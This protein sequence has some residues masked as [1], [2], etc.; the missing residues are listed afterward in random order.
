MH[1]KLQRRKGH[2]KRGATEYR[3][4]GQNGKAPSK[5]IKRLKK[6]IINV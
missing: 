6:E 2:K 1:L 5:E 4:R 3:R